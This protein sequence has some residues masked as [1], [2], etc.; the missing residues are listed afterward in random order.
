M[1][2]TLGRIWGGSD[3]NEQDKVWLQNYLHLV[4]L[5]R[6]AYNYSVTQ[7]DITAFRHHSIAYLDRL[8]TYHPTSI[9]PSHHFLLHLPELMERFGPIRGWWAFPFERFNGQ[10]QRLSTNHKVGVCLH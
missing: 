1:L 2:I 5:V 7:E 9:K 3:A 10:I 8:R 4:A 6:I